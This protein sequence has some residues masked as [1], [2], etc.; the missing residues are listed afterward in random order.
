MAQAQLD[1]ALEIKKEE[2]QQIKAKND[3]QNFI[4]SFEIQ[5]QTSGNTNQLD[6]NIFQDNKDVVTKRATKKYSTT[7]VKASNLLTNLSYTRYSSDIIL[8][9][10]RLLLIS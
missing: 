10:H 2:T 1:Y 7:K 5:Q 4:N 9:N 3:L 8:R 6:Q